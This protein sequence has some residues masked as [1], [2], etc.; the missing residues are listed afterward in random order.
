MDARTQQNER[1]DGS[2][3]CYQVVRSFSLDSSVAE[4]RKHDLLRNL[5]LTRGIGLY[6]QSRLK[7]SGFSDLAKL[8]EHP[9]WSE[10][11]A[12][13]IKAIEERDMAALALSGAS[14]PELLSFFSFSD[15]AVVDIETL[16]LTFNF[17]VVLVGVLSLS[18]GGYETRQYLAT[19]YHFEAAMLR[20]AISDLS[21]FSVVVTYNGK[22]FD[23]PY[24][25]YRANSLGLDQALDQVNIDLL[26][27]A[28]KHYGK[29]LPDCRLTTVERHIL[30]LGRAGDIPGGGVPLAF[31]RY[32]ETGDMDHLRPVID[33]NLLDLQSLFHLFLLALDEM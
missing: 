9:T 33:H 14:Y 27:H 28:R 24:V 7:A 19:D 8:T 15:I 21:R 26:F 23:V 13:V 1:T 29:R 31:S 32:L 5:T 20:E 4:P 16:G 22:A 12:V 25:N 17:P 3:G 2:H 6:R 10:R 18:S 30:G 11:A